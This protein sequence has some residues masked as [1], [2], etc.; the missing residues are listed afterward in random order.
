MRQKAEPRPSPIHGHGVFARE[1][2]HPGEF[3]GQYLGRRTDRD[4]MHTLWVD[5]GH[6]KRGY[7]GAGRL[8]FLNHASTPNAEFD[9]RNLH[10]L[11]TI[12]KDEE[13]TI[14]YGEEWVT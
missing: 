10:A 4:T 11:R 5:F 9:D 6:E 14:S 2:I 8:R 12:E 3:I 7:E 13:V 1:T